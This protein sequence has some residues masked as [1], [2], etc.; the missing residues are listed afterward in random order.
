M[1]DIHANTYMYVCR[2]THASVLCVNKWCWFNSTNETLL[3]CSLI[4]LLHC[5]RFTSRN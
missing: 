3:Q 4:I 5:S 1:D 2:N